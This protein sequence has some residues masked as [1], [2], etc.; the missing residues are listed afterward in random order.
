MGMKNS[1]ITEPYD[2]LRFFFEP[3]EIQLIYDTAHAIA[4]SATENGLDGRVIQHLLQIDTSLL[5]C[6]CKTV[7]TIANGIPYSYPKTPFLQML[8]TGI[9]VFQRQ[10]SRGTNDTDGITLAQKWWLTTHDPNKV[11][12][13]A[14]EE[15]CKR[16][17]TPHFKATLFF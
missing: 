12:V 6:S 13:V 14:L 8:H 9:G 10:I 15:T 2:P 16:C 11:K 17:G 5:I 3:P 7:K 4:T 1:N